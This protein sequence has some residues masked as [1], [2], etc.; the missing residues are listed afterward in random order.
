MPPNPRKQP[1]PGVMIRDAVAQVVR[2][3][4]HA[5][6]RKQLFDPREAGLTPTDV[7]LLEYID[8]KGPVRVSELA[9]Q[10]GVDKSTMTPQ[11]RRLE[12]K[13]LVDKQADPDDG[14]ATLVTASTAG[15][16]MHRNIGKA[17][18]AVVDE[19]LADWTDDDREAFARLFTRFAEQLLRGEPSQ[20]NDSERNTTGDVIKGS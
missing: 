14:R 3:A 10:Q 13:G 15:R 6:T 16:R 18:A 1:D 19:I 7:A 2:W 9:T 17:G 4:S 11:V 5:D 12:D 20:R 8:D